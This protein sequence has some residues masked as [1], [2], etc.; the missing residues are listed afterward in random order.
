M[1]WE[2]SKL[3]ITCRK[4]CFIDLILFSAKGP[5]LVY[6][7][8]WETFGRGQGSALVSEGLKEENSCWMGV[9]ESKA[10]EAYFISSR[11]RPLLVYCF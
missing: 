5:Y 4:P 1:E 2:G 3:S 7:I 6:V 9:W 8:C 11:G 10:V